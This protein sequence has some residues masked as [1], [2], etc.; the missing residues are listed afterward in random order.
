MRLTPITYSVNAN[1]VDSTNQSD[2]QLIRM[3]GANQSV[4]MDQVIAFKVGAALWNNVSTSTF[5][6]NYSAGT[7]ANGSTT[8]PSDPNDFTIIRSVRISMIG[9]TEPNPTN[10]YR[11]LFDS[12]PYQIRGNSIIVDPRNLSMRN[13]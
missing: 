11:N 4:L 9:R 5:E 6:Y 2:P 7:Y 10:P 8:T 13:N 12:G 3:Q 1:H